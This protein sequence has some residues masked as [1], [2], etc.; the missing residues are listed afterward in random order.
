MS[1]GYPDPQ[2]IVETLPSMTPEEQA[3][4]RTFC[5]DWHEMQHLPSNHLCGGILDLSSRT[6]FD[7]IM[8]RHG[9]RN[10]SDN[11]YPPKLT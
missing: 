2:Q 6:E 7:E 9:L 4:V 10:S 1:E 11:A 3:V 8:S 5:R